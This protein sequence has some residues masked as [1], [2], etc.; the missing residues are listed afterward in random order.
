MSS[1]RLLG[2]F[3]VLAAMT[4]VTQAIG[5][6]ALAI[7][8]RRLG[9]ES[10]GA[11][12]YALGVGLYFA[13]PANFGITIMGIRDVGRE[14]ERAREIAAE[15]LGVRLVLSA[16]LALAMLALTPVLAFDDQTRMVMPIAAATVLVGGVGAEWL[17]LGRQRMVGVGVGRLVGQLAY[18]AAII[19]F[20]RGDGNGA[21]LFC[22][23]TMG[24]IALTAVLNQI[25]VRDEIGR[26]RV[27]LDLS[28]LRRRAVDAVP[29]GVSVVAI[30]IYFSI[31]SIMLGV[32]SGAEAVGQYT[33]AYKIPLALYGVLGLWSA[34]LYPQA[35]R[36]VMDAPEQL[37]DQ[38]DAFTT[39]GIGLALPLAAGAAVLGTALIPVLFGTDFAAGGTPFVLLSCALALAIVAVGFSAVLAAGGDERRYALGVS[40]GAALNIAINVVAI[41]LYGT[42]GAAA[43]TVASEL[44]VV[45]YMVRRY[46]AVVGPIGV[47][48]R[49]VAR[50]AL[51]TAVMAGALLALH[52]L[53]VLVRLPIGAL[54]YAGAAVALGAVRPSDL[55]GGPTEPLVAGG[56]G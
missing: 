53:P 32:L 11:A 41:P 51:A 29:F 45:T 5:F 1:R 18:G 19:A 24:S 21:V 17:L 55:R 31:D 25:A 38:V 44:L 8:A 14:P 22:A 30:Q 26:P 20:V 49:R 34:S 56:S 28:R 40:L 13:I 10:L 2:G 43:A 54:V 35:A 3:A 7:A 42:T 46:G 37:R 33:V 12:N 36:L 6:V 15:V 39:L 48:G 9:P 47:D 23:F 27:C 4:F 16:T 50:A 52:G